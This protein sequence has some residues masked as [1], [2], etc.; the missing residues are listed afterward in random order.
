MASVL[1]QIEED[2]WIDRAEAIKPSKKAGLGAAKQRGAE[3]LVAALF[4]RILSSIVRRHLFNN[5]TGT[6]MADVLQGVDQ[7]HSDPSRGKEILV[8][9]LDDL[10]V[11][12]LDNL[13]QYQT[14]QSDLTKRLSSVCLM[15]R[16]S[17]V[18]DDDSYP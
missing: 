14:L 10:L 13:H 9:N 15:P 3:L 1:L 16:F 6:V 5:S 8:R 11:R 4:L 2:A 18:A 17:F 7:D 12:Y